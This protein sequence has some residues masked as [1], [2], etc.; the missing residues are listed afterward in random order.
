MVIQEFLEGTEISLHALCDGKS[1]KLFPTAQDHK[2]ALD[3][4]LG[5]NTGGMGTLFADA[6]LSERS[7]TGWEKASWNHG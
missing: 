4:D 7:R 2:R 3:G 6:F 5:L 1:A